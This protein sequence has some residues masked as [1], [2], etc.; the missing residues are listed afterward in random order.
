M[1]PTV[2]ATVTGSGFDEADA[3]IEAGVAVGSLAL[4]EVAATPAALKKGVL[5]HNNI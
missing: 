3:D 5:I 1:L 4:V 2:N